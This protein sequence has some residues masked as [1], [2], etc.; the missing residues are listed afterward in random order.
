MAVA[1]RAE[2]R[3]D[4]VSAFIVL[5]ECDCEAAAAAAAAAG[6]RHFVACGLLSER[7]NGNGVK[8]TMLFVLIDNV[9]REMHAETST[10]SNIHNQTG[11][12]THTKGGH[13][14]ARETCDAQIF[15]QPSATNLKIFHSYVD[16]ATQTD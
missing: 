14:N 3:S 6:G 16:Q 12:H 11:T 9:G 13:T 8:I 1:E 4:A 2:R 15:F 7:R 10:R 5:L